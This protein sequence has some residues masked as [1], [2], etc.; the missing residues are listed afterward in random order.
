MSVQEFLTLSMFLYSV[1]Y[2]HFENLCFLCVRAV[3]S[4]SVMSDSLQSHGL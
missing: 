3:L 1:K 2:K 4:R